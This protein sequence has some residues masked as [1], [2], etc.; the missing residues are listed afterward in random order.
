MKQ[1]LK[2]REFLLLGIMYLGYLE[3]T[4]VRYFDSLSCI[5]SL[6]GVPLEP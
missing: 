4:F 6:V 2:K 1:V 5:D 3:L